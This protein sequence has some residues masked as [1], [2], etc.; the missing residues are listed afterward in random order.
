MLFSFCRS[1]IYG[2]ISG[3][4]FKIILRRIYLIHHDVNIM[5]SRELILIFKISQSTKLVRFRGRYNFGSPLITKT[6]Q[7]R[8]N[9]SQMFFKTGVQNLAN[10]TAKHL[11]KVYQV[12]FCEIAK[13]LRAL[14]F[15]EHLR[16]L[17]LSNQRRL[18]RNFKS[19]L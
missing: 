11:C 14:S 8:G 15:T 6:C 3:L 19:F 16:W 5:F 10:F 17:L 18:R 13:F 12:F 2:K 7:S 1:R 4:V 9:R